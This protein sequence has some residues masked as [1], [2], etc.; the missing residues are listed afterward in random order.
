[1]QRE[2]ACCARQRQ[3]SLKRHRGTTLG[4][5]TRVSIKGR[6]DSSQ[7]VVKAIF[8][9]RDVRLTAANHDEVESQNRE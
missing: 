4:R 5:S 2:C 1:M 8:F 7:V 6:K 3:K 9:V